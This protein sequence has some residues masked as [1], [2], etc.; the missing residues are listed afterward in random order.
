MCLVRKSHPLHGHLEHLEHSVQSTVVGISRTSLHSIAVLQY[1]TRA[2]RS[3]ESQGECPA[4]LMP[5]GSSTLYDIGLCACERQS[6][7]QESAPTLAKADSLSGTG[8]MAGLVS[9]SGGRR[10]SDNSKARS[11]NLSER[12]ERELR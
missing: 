2:T 8:R 9:V 5:R 1:S 10:K 4:F 3:R 7:L 11:E 12:G 6:K